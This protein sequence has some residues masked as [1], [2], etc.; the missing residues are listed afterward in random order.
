MTPDELIRRL[1]ALGI[2]SSRTTLARWVRQ[3][4]IPAPA[5]RSLGRGRGSESIYPPSALG[6]AAASALLLGSMRW[7]EVAAIRR[8]ALL[9][10]REEDVAAMGGEITADTLPR[11]PPAVAERAEV[12]GLPQFIPPSA[13]PWVA[14]WV[15]VRDAVNRGEPAALV[16]Q[17][18]LIW[19][20]TGRGT[21]RLAARR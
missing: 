13:A 8:L 14:L 15:R 10:W 11:L 17:G 4:L 2:P 16:H 7:P 6:E 9:E 3:G 20:P 1:K 12:M 18:P 21:Y 19:E 5:R